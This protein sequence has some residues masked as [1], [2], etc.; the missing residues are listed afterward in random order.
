MKYIEDI[1]CLPSSPDEYTLITSALSSL[2][3]LSWSFNSFAS[4]DSFLF[5]DD[6]SGAC[7][8]V[9]SIVVDVVLGTL[10]LALV[11]DSFSFAGWVSVG[12]GVCASGSV[13]GCSVGTLWPEKNGSVDTD[14]AIDRPLSDADPPPLKINRLQM[15]KWIKNGRSKNDEKI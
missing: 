5:S 7:D 2:L 4:G 6:V 13:V 9:A 11:S 1:N 14:E 15:V 12:V 10:L 8:V 3:A